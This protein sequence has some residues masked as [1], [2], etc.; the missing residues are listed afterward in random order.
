MGWDKNSPHSTAPITANW[1][2]IGTLRH[3]FT[4]FHADLSVLA[5]TTSAT[6]DHGTFQPVNPENLPTLMRKAHSLASPALLPR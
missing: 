4:H 1:Q 5:A 2:E 6:P 3:T